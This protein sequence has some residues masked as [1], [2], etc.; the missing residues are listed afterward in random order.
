MEGALSRRFLYPSTEQQSIGKRLPAN[1][2][3]S[4]SAWVLNL[5]FKLF[6]NGISIQRR[7]FLT[8]TAATATPKQTAY[9]LA[10]RRACRLAY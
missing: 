3:P 1:S 8:T 9:Q 10:N 6:L 4:I 5:G 2:N 7:F